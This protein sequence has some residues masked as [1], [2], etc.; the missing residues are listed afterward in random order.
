MNEDKIYILSTNLKYIFK[1]I[2]DF[3][4]DK[5]ARDFVNGN[6][7]SDNCSLEQAIKSVIPY[8]AI[9]LA[10]RKRR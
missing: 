6:G 5:V 7:W 2:T 8:M 10:F 3:D 4:F 9:N 1:S